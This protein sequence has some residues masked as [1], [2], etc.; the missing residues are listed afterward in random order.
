MLW[1][2]KLENDKEIAI[3]LQLLCFLISKEDEFVDKI[4]KLQMSQSSQNVNIVNFLTNIL[5]PRSF[6]ARW[7]VLQSYS[8][9][10]QNKFTD[11][12]L[13][14]SYI[15]EEK[16]RYININDI[17]WDKQV[18]KYLSRYGVCKLI[19]DTKDEKTLR[20]ELSELLTKPVDVDFLQLFIVIVGIEKNKEGSVVT[21][22]LR[23]EW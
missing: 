14:K 11:P 2:D 3:D 8:P 6:E 7:Q 16:I 13:V 23:E 4:S 20:K 5:W 17:D 10:N 18:S 19:A 9:F 1:R 21:L 15:L 12:Q 22:K